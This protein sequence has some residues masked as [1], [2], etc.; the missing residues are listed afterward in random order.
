[1][2]QQASNP[3][4]T[5]IPDSLSSTN[6]GQYQH[7]AAQHS[8]V[9][10]ACVTFPSTIKRA[11][12]VGIRVL[13]NPD[14][15]DEDGNYDI[16]YPRVLGNFKLDGLLNGGGFCRVAKGVEVN[17]E[18]RQ[19][20][21]IKI[22]RLGQESRAA[23]KRELRVL[24]ALET[25]DKE[26]HKRFTRLRDFFEFGGHIFIVMD[27]LDQSIYDFLKDNDFIPFPDSHIQSFAQQIFSSIKCEDDMS[28]PH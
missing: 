20:V 25:N 23:A 1:M 16:T 27:L 24:K 26:Y 4:Y 22:S 13:R 2:T 18:A 14:C 7:D 17:K 10:S 15:D 28:A 3:H 9:P 21:A 19:A 6:T 5:I 8:R 11:T 12:E